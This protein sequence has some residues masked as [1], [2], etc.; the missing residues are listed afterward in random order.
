MGSTGH[1]SSQWSPFSQHPTT[2]TAVVGVCAY[3]GQQPGH[4]GDRSSCQSS[5]HPR[6][7]W[8]CIACWRAFSHIVNPQISIFKPFTHT[9]HLLRASHHLLHVPLTCSGNMAAIMEVSDDMSKTFQ[10]F[11]PAPRRGE[12]E[13]AQSMAGTRPDYFL[14]GREN[15]MSVALIVHGMMCRVLQYI[16]PIRTQSN[17]C[18][19]QHMHACRCAKCAHLMTDLFTN[20]PSLAYLVCSQ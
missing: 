1:T 6:T 16:R 11:E 17:P 5:L 2:A 8:A 15:N 10:K 3:W 7:A 19:C 13:S 9:A 14:V 20:A 4:V 18:V 12:P